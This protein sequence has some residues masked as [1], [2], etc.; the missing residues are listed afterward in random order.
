MGL[1]PLTDP[2]HLSSGTAASPH[3]INI[4]SWSAYALYVYTMNTIVFN[5]LL[6]N[7]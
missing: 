1:D 5:A 3:S 7:N 2:K 6:L 4:I